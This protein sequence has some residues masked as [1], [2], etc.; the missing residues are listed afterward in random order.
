MAAPV[1][2]KNSVGAPPG[3]VANMRRDSES[4]FGG[5][6]HPGRSGQET[7]TRSTSVWTVAVVPRK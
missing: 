6:F 5:Y 4:T 3:L 2:M 7:I 1:G